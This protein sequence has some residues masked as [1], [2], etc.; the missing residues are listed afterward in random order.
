[1]PPPG[2]RKSVTRFK[3]DRILSPEHLKE[4]QQL[5]KDPRMTVKKLHAWVRELG[6]KIG[7]ASIGRH[8]R[9]FDED[10]EAVRRTA[11]LAEHFA[12]ASRGGGM[13]VLCDATVSRFQ[14][15]LLE[16]LMRMDKPDDPKAEKSSDFTPAQWLEL[17]KTIAASVSARRSLETLRGEYEDRARKAAEAVEKAAGEKKKP[18]DGVAVANAVRRILGVPLPDEPLPEL[19][20]PDPSADSMKITP[21]WPPGRLPSPS[22]N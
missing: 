18:L 12:E 20:A 9:H 4:Y 17:A 16:R 6:Y 11:M 7:P 2:Y 19:P 21:R 15:V 1:M 8:R 5:V 14:Q 3:I 22:D 13:T 10:V